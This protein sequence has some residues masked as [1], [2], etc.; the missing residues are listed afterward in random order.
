M[1]PR[2]ALAGAVAGALLVMSAAGCGYTTRGGLDARYQT[3]HVAPFED[4]SQEYDLQAPL[5]NALIR[6]F[7][8]DGRLTVVER[9]RADLLLEGV[10]LDYA[11]RGLS[12]DE[13]D[14]VTQFILVVVAGARVTDQAT[15]DVLWED[16]QLSG[17]TSYYSLAA[18]QSSDRLRGNAEVF[19]PGVRS[20]TREEENRGASEALEVLASRIFYRTVAPW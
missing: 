6:K 9:D 19:M 5:T 18:G 8:H 20:F 15:G 3:I 13:R 14:N 12:F 16:G 1:R 4:I 11:M 2:G 17:E 10:I 7:L